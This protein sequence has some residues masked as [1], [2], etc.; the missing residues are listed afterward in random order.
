MEPETCEPENTPPKVLGVNVALPCP[1]QNNE[2]VAV[3]PAL[4]CDDT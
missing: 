4:G 3:K 1:K 2:S